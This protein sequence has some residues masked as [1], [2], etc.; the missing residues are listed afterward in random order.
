VLQPPKSDWSRHIYPA[1][2][3]DEYLMYRSGENW[4]GEEYTTAEFI[5]NL[6]V[7]VETPKMAAGTAVHELVENAKFG[8]V[9]ERAELNGWRVHFKLDAEIRLPQ[10][11]EIRLW[12]HHKHITV[13]GR[14]DA[15]DGGTVHD[16]KTTSST[17]DIE[18]YLDSYQWR[19]YLWMSGRSRFVYDVLRVDVDDA[20]KAVE[21]RDY[22]RIPVSA[23]PGLDRDVEQTLEAFDQCVHALGIP[24]ILAQQKRAA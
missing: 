16:I 15:I 7:R 23:Y 10:M 22:M 17:I 14:C 5:R 20:E 12:G 11:R 8:A 2:R 18:R 3:L 4:Q 13:V 24:A 6:T 1:S 9:P 21:V 19:A